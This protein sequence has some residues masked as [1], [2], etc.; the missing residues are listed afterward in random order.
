MWRFGSSGDNFTWHGWMVA[1]RAHDLAQVAAWNT[2][3]SGSSAGIWSSGEAPVV[4]GSNNLYV[5]TGNGTFDG[6]SNF[7]CSVV[8]LSTT[9]VAGLSV[10]DYFAPFN[11]SQLTTADNDFGSGGVVLLPDVAG[12]TAHPH[13]LAASGKSG[14]VYLLD[15]DH[16]GGFSG[17]TS[18]PDAQIVQEIFNALGD[19]SLDNF[20]DPMAS[21]E[22]SF[23]TPAFWRDAAGNNHLYWAGVGDR[24]KMFNL[25]N[26]QLS[27]AAV[28]QSATTYGFP[29][30]SPSISSNGT[31]NGI[32]WAVE[33][34]RSAA[35]LH[36]YDATNLGLELYNSTEAAN[37][38]D[39]LGPRRQV[40]DPGGHRGPRV[41]RHPF[42]GR[43]VRRA[44]GGHDVGPRRPLAGPVAL[45]VAAGGPGA[46]RARPAR[47]PVSARAHP[48][49]PDFTLL[50]GHRDGRRLRR[51]APAR[52]LRITARWIGYM[53]A[54]TSVITLITT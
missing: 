17:S 37:G 29:G 22:D 27:A 15:R 31:G 43:R 8:K 35:V 51:R 36:A 11:Q 30:A 23:S 16:L 46:T 44:G 26:G 7:G 41:R 50:G 20:S 38:R 49:P 54:I 28:S 48:T 4:D 52:R 13:L 12:T 1:Y 24:L 53:S 32:L 34:G 33:K 5:P 19:T 47:P 42:D 45:C 3:P 14:T 40:R 39:S 6:A 21:V 18:S 10:A 9:S 2:T 25:T